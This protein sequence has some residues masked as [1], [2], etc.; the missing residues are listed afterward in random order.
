MLFQVRVHFLWR[1]DLQVVLGSR[2]HFHW[3]PLLQVV[4]GRTVQYIY[5]WRQHLQVVPGRRDYTSTEGSIY[6]LYQV[7]EYISNWRQHLQ[8][9][10]GR[11]IHFYWRQHLQAVPGRR[12]PFHWRL[13][14]QVFPGRRVH[15]HFHF[16]EAEQTSTGASLRVSG[17]PSL[18]CATRCSKGDI[19]DRNMASQVADTSNG[20][21]F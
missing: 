15:F 4:P 11:K 17:S 3:R 2:V 7:E 18:R 10:P 6:R 13:H 8:V 19:F 12:V 1:Q 14:L 9:V 21:T 20:D 5:N 16:Q